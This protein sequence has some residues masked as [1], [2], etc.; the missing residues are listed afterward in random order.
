MHLSMSLSRSETSNIVGPMCL[1]A[2][3]LIVQPSVHYLHVF[4]LPIISQWKD[5]TE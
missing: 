5:T 2:P 3:T 1:S 4:G